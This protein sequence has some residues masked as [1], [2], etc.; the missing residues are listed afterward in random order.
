MVG[1]YSA[2]DAGWKQV[3]PALTA[4]GCSS[5]LLEGPQAARGYI[6]TSAMAYEARQRKPA[7]NLQ[8]PLTGANGPKRHVRR[9]VRTGGP[10]QTEQWPRSSGGDAHAIRFPKRIEEPLTI[11]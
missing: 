6:G 7:T 11:E 1:A 4:Q 5:H 3:K 9:Q 2:T 10:R 8:D